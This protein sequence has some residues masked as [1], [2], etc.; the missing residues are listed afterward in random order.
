[1][2]RKSCNL[3]KNEAVCVFTKQVDGWG[4][5]ALANPVALNEQVFNPDLPK[6]LMELIAE[7]CLLYTPVKPK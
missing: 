3:C 1:M 2:N 5:H 7:N 6:K 4:I